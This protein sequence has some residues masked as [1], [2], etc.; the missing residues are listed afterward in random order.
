MGS[1]PSIIYVQNILWREAYRKDLR[2][3]MHP[4]LDVLVKVNSSLAEEH[5]I[6]S[7]F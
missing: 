4:T 1:T 6:V 5:S 3:G 7:F 2:V